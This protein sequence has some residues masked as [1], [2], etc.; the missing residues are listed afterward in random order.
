MIFVLTFIMTCGCS[1]EEGKEKEKLYEIPFA[2]LEEK[3]EGVKAKL[4][5]WDLEHKRIKDESKI[6]YTILKK[7]ALE[8]IYRKSPISWDG[9]GHLV[10]PSYAQVS[11][12][13]QVSVEKVEIPFQKK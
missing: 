13:Y 11:Q 1:T 9:K 2:I 6:I 4:Y 5:Y 7:N 10:I 8:G 12:E 3:E